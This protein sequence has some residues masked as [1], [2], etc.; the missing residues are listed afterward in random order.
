MN[1]TLTAC[2]SERR[3]A[4]W[5]SSD[6]SAPLPKGL[7]MLAWNASVGYSR[8]S[9]CSQRLVTHAGTCGWGVG[10]GGGGVCVDEGAWQG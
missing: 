10:G 8:D 4:S 2:L 5:R 1:P 3:R 6:S 9:V 7:V